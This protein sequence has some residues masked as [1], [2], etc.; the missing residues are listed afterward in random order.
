LRKKAELL[1]QF[2]STAPIPKHRS[3]PETQISGSTHLNIENYRS[4][5]LLVSVSTAT[6]LTPQEDDERIGNESRGKLSSSLDS[7]SDKSDGTQKAKDSNPNSN[8]GLLQK[9][10]VSC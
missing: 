1:Q 9:E 2:G 10:V 3:A 8:P 7:T 5:Q 4:Q 6:K